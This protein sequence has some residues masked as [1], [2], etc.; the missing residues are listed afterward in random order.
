MVQ[1]NPKL[2]TLLMLQYITCRKLSEA[3]V[4]QIILRAVAAVFVVIGALLWLRLLL[5]TITFLSEPRTN[6]GEGLAYGFTV[7]GTLFFCSFT[8]PAGFLTYKGRRLSLALVLAAFPP[9]AAMFLF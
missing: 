4:I 9:L 8:V 6:L 1:S 5:H 3:F 2:L 7:L